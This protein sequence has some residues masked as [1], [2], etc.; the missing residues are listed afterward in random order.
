MKPLYLR[1]SQF[2][3]DAQPTRINEEVQTEKRA[4]RNRPIP[5][6]EVLGHLCDWN[7][8]AGQILGG[9]YFFK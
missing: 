7:Y 8:L 9:E 2:F 3:A 5:M 1:V 4:E 6:R